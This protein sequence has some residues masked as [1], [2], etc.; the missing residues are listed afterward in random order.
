MWAS[1]LG[2]LHIAKMTFF[3]LATKGGLAVIQAC[4]R[5]KLVK[6]LSLAFVCPS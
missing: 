5:K 3:D 2:F 1:K 4:V 6:S